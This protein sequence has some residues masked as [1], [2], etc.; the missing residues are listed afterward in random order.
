MTKKIKEVGEWKVTFDDLHQVSSIINQNTGYQSLWREK[1]DSLER[2]S[3][4]EKMDDY[5]FVDFCEMIQNNKS[6]MGFFN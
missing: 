2:L 6:A 4:I 3:Y 5:Q 1:Q